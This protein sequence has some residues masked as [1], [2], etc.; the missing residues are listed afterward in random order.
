MPSDFMGKYFE[1]QK[2]SLDELLTAELDRQVKILYDAWK[3]D[4]QVFIIGNGG[5][6]ST[7][8]H[9]ACDLGKST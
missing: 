2:D 6:A 8:S 1:W 9:F 4:K 5:S 3:Q 7:A